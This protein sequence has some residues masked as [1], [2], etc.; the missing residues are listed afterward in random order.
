MAKSSRKK[1][2]RKAQ[3][4]EIEQKEYEDAHGIKRKVKYGYSDGLSLKTIKTMKIVLLVAGVAAYFLYSVLLMPIVLVY[5]LLYFSVRQKERNMNYGM[6][7]ELWVKLPKFDSIVAL[8]IVIVTV[9]MV[10]LSALSMRSR[11]STFTGK[12]EAQVYQILVNRGASV[13]DAEER[14]KEMVENGMT[15]TTSERY[16]YQSGTLLTGYRELFQS[17]Y[18]AASSFGR[19]MIRRPSGAPPSG[20]SGGGNVMKIKRPDGS[21][22]TS[23]G[24]SPNF[25]GSAG[26][27]MNPMVMASIT[28]VLT[29]T[30]YILLVIMVA[31]GIYVAVSKKKET[32]NKKKEVKVRT[33]TTERMETMKIKTVKQYTDARTGKVYYVDDIRVVTLER[34]E[35]ICRKGYAV[36]FVSKTDKYKNRKTR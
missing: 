26:F 14:A 1:D 20:G 22:H 29:T 10:G 31:G 21:V 33:E 27:R 35:E 12:S 15:L 23:S 30:N 6:R 36:E 2:F 8:V 24:A 11:S 4:A 25:F 28:R 7:K 18:K 19:V 9:S 16:M 17:K 34:G 13:S 32:E 3:E 5:G